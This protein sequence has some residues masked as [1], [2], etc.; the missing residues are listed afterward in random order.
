[1][2][3]QKKH[4]TPALTEQE[5]TKL[6]NE[7]WEEQVSK[8]LPAETQEQAFR[9]GAFMRSREI[10]SVS[11][12]L[13]ALLAYVLCVHSFRQLGGPH[14]LG[15]HLRCCLAQ[16]T[17][18]S[19]RMVDVVVGSFACRTTK[20][21]AGSLSGSHWGPSLAHIFIPIKETRGRPR[22]SHLP[23]RSPIIPPDPKVAVI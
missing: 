2:S 22:V 9:L 21:A 6:I 4:T 13:R 18:T 16:A 10:Q 3:S 14:R 20:Y 5:A 23:N 17:A 19:T 15:Q 12:L 1:M 11:D 7:E 8:R